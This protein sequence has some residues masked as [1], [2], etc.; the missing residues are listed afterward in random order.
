MTDL[1]IQT[2]AIPGAVPA[3]R[4]MIE[5]GTLR[6][7]VEKAKAQKARLVALWGSDETT[8]GGGYAL[9]V[10]LAVRTGLL[11]LTVPLAREHPRYPGIADIYPSANRMQRAAYDLLGIHAQD[12]PDRRKWL[13]HRAWPGG[14]FPLRKEFDIGA[15]F[16]ASDDRYPF[17]KVEGEGVHEIP[18]G[19]VH[20]GTIEPGHFR[21][22]IVGEKIL[23]L[24]ERL[25][26]KH[27]GIEKRFEA[28]TLEAGARLA[29]RVSGDST[30]AYAWAYAM[31]LEGMTGTRPSARALHLR[32]L[33]LERERVAN[34]LGDLG[35]IGNDCALAFGFAQFWRMKEDVLRSNARAFGHRYLMDRVVPGGV[36]ADVDAASAQAMIAEALRLKDEL[37]TL[38]SIY[39]NHAGLQDRC[40]TT[41]RLLPP[42]AARLGVVGLAARA[43]GLAMDARVH[44]GLAPYD[45]LQP[46]IA[47]HHNG[48]VA[49]RIVVRFEEAFESLRLQRHILQNL[50][51][52]ALQTALA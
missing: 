44:P 39:Y 30:V 27:K 17:V 1:P 18:V 47:S 24:E 29:G 5:A 21:F 4:S 52:G 2:E 22:S 48:D 33:L 25:G 15:S 42:T 19:P 43:S 16:P 11:W 34:H 12:A 38:R 8:R 10:A 31:A 26:Y 20:A 28:M 9:Q 49:A 46:K 45:E 50:P 13:R 41:G 6:A 32:A 3:F 14:V 7:V 36:A 35:Y 51:Q 40:I 23:R 37:R